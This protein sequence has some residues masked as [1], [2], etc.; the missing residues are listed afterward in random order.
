MCQRSE[1][2][3]RQM[4]KVRRRRR[5]WPDGGHILMKVVLKRSGCVLAARF[6]YTKAAV[7]CCILPFEHLV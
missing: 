7:A 4:K 6:R 3:Y 2:E 1:R 5:P